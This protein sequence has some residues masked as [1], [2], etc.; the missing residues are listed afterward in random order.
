VGEEVRADRSKQ[1]QT[2]IYGNDFECHNL[3][4]GFHRK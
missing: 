4:I 1:I 2:A 3:L